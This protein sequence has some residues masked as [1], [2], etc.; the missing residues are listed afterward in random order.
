M[1]VFKL[2]DFYIEHSHR[3]F[4]KAAIQGPSNLSGRFNE[5][6]RKQVAWLSEPRACRRIVA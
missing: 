1:A 5:L 4:V 2:N 3:C 6:R